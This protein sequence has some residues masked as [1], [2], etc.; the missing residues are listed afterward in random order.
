MNLNEPPFELGE[1]LSGKDA[2]GNLINGHWLGQIFEFPAL[3]KRSSA[4]PGS[5]KKRRT[6]RTIKAIALRNESG[7]TMYGKRLAKF[8]LTAGP[9]AFETVNGYPVAT[10]EKPCVIID[11]YLATSGVADDDI[12]W[13]ILEGPVTCIMQHE[14]LADGIVAVGDILIAG[15]GGGTSGNSTSGGVAKLTITSQSTASLQ[16][17]NVI[18]VALS[19]MAASTNTNSD[20]LVMAAIRYC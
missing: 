13:G 18:G 6:G 7:Y 11:E 10:N 17:Q 3:P 4:A 9:T 19:A 2:D 16:P 8:G 14:D 15:T 12:F 1:T 5:A 20:I